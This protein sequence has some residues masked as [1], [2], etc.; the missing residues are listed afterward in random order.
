[1]YSPAIQTFA[2]TDLTKKKKT[3]TTDRHTNKNI[4]RWPVLML[5]PSSYVPSF[6]QY[7]YIFKNIYIY[8]I[9]KLIL[10]VDVICF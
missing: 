5:T 10:V 2:L 3:L 7:T 9:S 8:Y 4:L 1:M 6:F